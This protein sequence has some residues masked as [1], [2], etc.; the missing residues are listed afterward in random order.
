MSYPPPPQPPG[1]DAPGSYG[2]S[3]TPAGPTSEEKNWALA[4]HIGVFVAAWIAMGFLAPL[5]IMLVKGNESAF[6]RRHSVESLNFQLSMLIY[7]VAA[8]LIVLVTFGLGAIVIV[9]LAIVVGIAYVVVVILAT[10]K[11]ANGED[12]RYPLTIRMVS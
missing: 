8:F 5:I 11:A 6:V 4:S 1:G 7:G 3:G 2:Y 9:P 12:Y 10:V